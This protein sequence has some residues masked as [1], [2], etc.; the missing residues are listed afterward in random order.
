MRIYE[1]VGKRVFDILISLTA[2]II[3]SPI[4]L[5]V[6]FVLM[7]S[8]K[9][10]PFFVQER[11][12][13]KERSFFLIKFRT[14]SNKRGADGE[15]LNDTL[16][17]S[18]IGAYIRR[19]SLD[20]LPQLF[21]VLFGTMSLVGPRPLLMRYLPF[22][23]P[24]ERLRHDCKPGITGMA[25]VNG[26]NNLSWE[27]RIQLDI[28]YVKNISFKNDLIII[29]QTIIAVLTS[30]GVVVDPGSVLQNLD[31]QRKRQK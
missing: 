30:R 23:Y 22:Y 24:S 5:I 31:D 16:R 7:V 13:Y 6:G 2:L 19:K 17:L 18:K 26:R 25:Q 11:P 3:L 14:M 4:L 29:Y 10:N 27:E 8:L 28:H 1:K 21:N 9:G 20:E 12:G 15:L